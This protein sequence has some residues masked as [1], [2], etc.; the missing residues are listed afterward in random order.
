VSLRENRKRIRGGKGL[1]SSRNFPEKERREKGK[2]D[3]SAFF[4]LV[5]SLECFN[6]EGKW[7]MHKGKGIIAGVKPLHRQEGCQS[8]SRL[9]LQR[10]A[11]IPGD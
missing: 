2:I 7:M 10:R 4:K 8:V 11:F 1:N 5:Y 9:A 6:R 3:M